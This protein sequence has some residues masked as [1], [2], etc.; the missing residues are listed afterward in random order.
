VED[1]KR[2]LGFDP[3]LLGRDADRLID[4]VQRTGEQAAQIVGTAE[5]ADGRIKVEY[6]AQD[7]VR[8]LT[9]DPRAMRMSSGELAETIQSLIAQARADFAAQG[10]ELV[11]EATA[12]SP[13]APGRLGEAG[14]TA[15]AMLDERLR[16]SMEMAER[17]RGLL[18]R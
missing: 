5:S 2:I 14:R 17:L 3:E 16:E 12:T 8:N 7:G 11:A 9:L 13:L 1:L 18:R 4:A 15:E 6:T 10:R